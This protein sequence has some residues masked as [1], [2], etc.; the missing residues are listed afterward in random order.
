M[1]SRPDM[2]ITETSTAEHAERLLNDKVD[3]LCPR[4]YT[5]LESSLLQYHTLNF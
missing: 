3:L 2:K 5:I 1:I 4:L